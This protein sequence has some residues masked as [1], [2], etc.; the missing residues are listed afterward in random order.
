[1]KIKNYKDSNKRK[2]FKKNELDIKI[3]KM[4]LVSLDSHQNLFSK[5]WDIYSDQ[6]FYQ[7]KYYLLVNLLSMNRNS[8]FTRVV[9]RCVVT[10]RSKGV[11]RKQKLS[12]IMIKKFAS[13]G[14]LPGY[15]KYNW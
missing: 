10:G 1:M 8:F 7:F 11:Y 9:N 5:D 2:L 12:R 6:T 3:F 15:S 4:L 14:S 13:I